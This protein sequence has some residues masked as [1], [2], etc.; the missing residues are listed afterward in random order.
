ML[1]AVLLCAFLPCA[2]AAHALDWPMY[3]R[4]L[5]HSFTNPD[6]DK[7]GMPAVLT[8]TLVEHNGLKAIQVKTLKKAGKAGAA[9]GSAATTAAAKK[10]AWAC[11][12][13]CEGKTYDKAGKCPVCG[14]DLEKKK[15]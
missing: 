8:G 1:R 5:H 4:D 13:N 6:A 3:G 9:A 10:D 12:M 15:G 14:M 2:S 7:A 11:P